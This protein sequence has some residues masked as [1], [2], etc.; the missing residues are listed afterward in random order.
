V[1]AVD[2]PVGG[3]TVALTMIVRDA[4]A[5]IE[6]SLESALPFI[7]TWTVVDTGSE[8]AT[9][10]LVESMLGG[11]PGGLHRRP[12][13]DF[14]S[15]RSEALDLARSSADYLLLLDADEVVSGVG[16]PPLWMDAYDVALLDDERWAPRVVR[17][18]LPWRFVGA[19]QDRLACAVPVAHGRMPELSILH[20]RDEDARVA[21]LRRDVQLLRSSSGADPTDL[22]VVFDLARLV[23]ELGDPVEAGRLFERCVAAGHWAELAFCSAHHLAR[24]AALDD[25]ERGMELLLAAWESRPGRAEPLLDLARLANG[26][27][28]PA[29]GLLAT[30]VGVALPEPTQELGVEPWAYRWHLRLEHAVSLHGVGRG[31]EARTVLDE[32]IADPELPHPLLVD[33]LVVRQSV[34]DGATV[35]SGA[36]PQ[37]E[38]VSVASLGAPP[39]LTEILGNVVSVELGLPVPLPAPW[40]L[41][42]VTVAGNADGFA[43]LLTAAGVP[44]VEGHPMPHRHFLQAH[45]ATGAPVLVQEVLAEPDR[46]DLGLPREGFGETRLFWWE[47]AWH[48]LATA[49]DGGSGDEAE[50]SLITVDPAGPTPPVRVL[51]PLGSDGRHWA[52][53]VVGD[54]L[55]VVTGLDPFAA[56]TWDGTRQSLGG[57]PRVARAPGLEG[58]SG[59]SAG[60]RTDDGYLFVIRRVR[61]G[62]RFQVTTHRFLALDDRLRPVG[63]SREFVF[64]R[65][66]SEACVGLARSGGD[67]LCAYASDQGRCWLTAVQLDAVVGGLLPLG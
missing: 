62:H 57:V 54:Q 18:D 49:G 22:R 12:W 39:L 25:P 21:A 16:L 48:G 40:R 17:A 27:G 23:L 6:A 46:G 38:D 20:L 8:D 7:D 42:S 61:R 41:T 52:P 47:G 56:S 28:R 35:A 51:P 14:G 37:P 32:L 63:A 65:F 24:I 33:G 10:H 1:T 66:G 64:Q 11:V 44:E 58:W 9:P 30:S 59:G 2:P 19:A 43:L 60:L 3:R 53:V 45:D 26:A 15:N 13:R 36:R 29:R 31:A 50:T 34:V 67:L 55:L 5:T 4:A